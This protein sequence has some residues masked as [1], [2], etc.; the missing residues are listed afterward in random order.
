MPVCSAHRGQQ[1]GS[2]YYGDLS[3]TS[4]AR[5]ILQPFETLGPIAFE[6]P[7]HRGLTFADNDGNLGDLESLFRREQ[8]HLG[9]LADPAGVAA[10]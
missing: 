5:C 9:T 4:G 6:P 8:D 10:K 2:V 3:R 7:E 1:L